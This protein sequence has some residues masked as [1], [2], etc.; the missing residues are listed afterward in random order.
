MSHMCDEIACLFSNTEGEL[1]KHEHFG[2]WVYCAV[3]LKW[4]LMS[5]LGDVF[6][7]FFFSSLSNGS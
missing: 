5:P 7:L 1:S 3:T 6:K 2:M 4:G